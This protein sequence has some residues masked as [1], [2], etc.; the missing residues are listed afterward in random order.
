MGATNQLRRLPAP[1]AWANNRRE[2]TRMSQL[3][4][5]DAS[6]ANELARYKRQHQRAVLHGI[7]ACFGSWIGAFLLG[8]WLY[9]SSSG[10]A[11]YLL[12]GLLLSVMIGSPAIGL[13]VYSDAERRAGIVIWLRK[14]HRGP[15]VIGPLVRA[16]TGLLYPV[17]LRDSTYKSDASAVLTRNAA[18]VALALFVW[19][20]GF[21]FVAVVLAFI[22][23]AISAS[24]GSTTTTEPPPA[25]FVVTV[26][27][28]TAAY[29][30]LVAKLFARRGSRRVRSVADISPRLLSLELGHKG[31]G[32]QVEI[33]ECDREDKDLWKPVV[34][35]VYM[36]A[37]A[38]VFDLT[39]VSPS[40]EIKWEIERA[41]ERLGP[42]KVILVAREGTNLD[43]VWST[44]FREAGVSREW[45]DNAVIVYPTTFFNGPRLRAATAQLRAALERSVLA[46]SGL[47]GL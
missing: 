12:Q 23:I 21:V 22:M 25:V 37:R 42:E 3:F 5:T 9:G 6:Q 10:T 30:Y 39:E 20:L 36:R 33:L 17:T 1:R 44:S 7:G 43:L 18:L 26:L 45:Y 47:S 19:V 38:A 40:A 2:G 15:G 8:R 28:Y 31:F 11:S 29:V 34:A 4:A 27:A 16:S 32:G 46:R 41:F 35:D 13:A 14:F 24:P